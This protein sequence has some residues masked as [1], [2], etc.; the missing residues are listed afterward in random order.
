MGLNQT[1]SPRSISRLSLYRRLLA[2]CAGGRAGR[3]YS[4]ELGRCAGVSAAQV[5]RDIMALGYSGTPNTGYEVQALADHISAH[6]DA[7]EGQQVALVGVGNLGKAILTYFSQG[8]KTTLRLVAAFD[9]V[10]EKTDRVLHG[11]RCYGVDKL[12]EVIRTERI[13]VGVIAVPADAAQ[14]TAD[15]LVA[16]GVTGI[17]NFSPVPIQAP[18]RVYVENVDI[19]IR[20]E[21]VA[22]FARGGNPRAGR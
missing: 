16:A 2:T 15:A 9:T 22:F 12:A 14:A 10:P 18:P 8:R 20:L 11:C 21:T 1:D 7:A 5:R 6:L 3:V 17:L 13:S 4:H 19:T